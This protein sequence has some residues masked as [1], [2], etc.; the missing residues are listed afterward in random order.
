MVSYL[1]FE[2]RRFPKKAILEISFLQIAIF[3]LLVWVTDLDA[4]EDQCKVFVDAAVKR[5]Y[6]MHH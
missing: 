4:P 3:F 2:Y 6:I 5:V 1:V